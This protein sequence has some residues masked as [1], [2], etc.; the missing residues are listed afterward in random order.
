MAH[1]D[2]YEEFKALLPD[3]AEDVSDWFPNGKDS[4]RIRLGK[5][6]QEFIFTIRSSEEWRFETLANFIK[7][8]NENRRKGDM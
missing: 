1:K 2:V 6:H 4:V 7:S 8:L 3:Y 5:T